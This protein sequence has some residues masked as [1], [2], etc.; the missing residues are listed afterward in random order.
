MGEVK[1]M[2]EGPFG[3]MVHYL[4]VTMP[5][6]GKP[7]TDW[8]QMVDAFPVE[9][10]CDEVELT[11]AKWLIF[12][13]GQNNGYYCSPN[14]VLERLLPGHCSERDLMREI[15]ATLKGK[16]IRLIAYLPSEPDSAVEEIRNAFGWDVDPVDKSGFQHVYMEFIRA[17]A[18]RFG[19]L[20]DGWWFDGCY[21]AH[22]YTFLRTQQWSNNRFDYSEWSAAARAGNP[23][24]V[25]AMNPGVGMTYV[26][27]EQDYIAG[28]VNDL[29]YL[30]ENALINGMQ[31]HA[32]TWIDC[33]WGH[34]EK[35]GPIVPPR[36]GDEEL[37]AYVSACHRVGGAVTLN[38]GIYQEGNMAEASLRQARRI[39]L[40]MKG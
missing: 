13:F 32:L 35:P 18:E 39:A 37:L 24:A 17:W 9:S 34:T 31:W 12:P 19:T 27:K 8:D 26:F 20:I 38:V 16:G 2:Q 22:K 40:A 30:P 28:E 3:L 5:S 7:I 23:D 1:W 15:A 14:P 11:G 25:V 21:D 10:F 29:S 4:K 6:Q 36:F 33:F